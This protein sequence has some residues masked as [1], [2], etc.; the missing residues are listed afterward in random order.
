MVLIGP[1]GIQ[2]IELDLETK[3]KSA[4]RLPARDL[5][6]LAI[7]IN[8]RNFIHNYNIRVTVFHSPGAIRISSHAA[9]A[10]AASRDLRP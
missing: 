3:P 8:K 4:E 10:R 2:N 7:L 5:I 6:C 9:T 1:G